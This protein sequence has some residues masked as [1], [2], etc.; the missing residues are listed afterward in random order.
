MAE[1]NTLIKRN[2]FE[3]LKFVEKIAPFFFDKLDHFT[4]QW[5][6]IFEYETV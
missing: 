5:K 6:S 4:R 1:L 2:N 3:I